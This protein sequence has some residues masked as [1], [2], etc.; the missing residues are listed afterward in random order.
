MSLV[1]P[2]RAT[3]RNVSSPRQRAGLC[4]RQAF[5]RSLY[6]LSPGKV[7]ECLCDCGGGKGGGV[8]VKVIGGRMCAG[9][10]WESV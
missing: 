6:T 7:G 8:C 4:H 1:R 5:T 3:R 9:D 10:W 2:S